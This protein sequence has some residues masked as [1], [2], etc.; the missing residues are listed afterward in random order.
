MNIESNTAWII[1]CK[2]QESG[3]LVNGNLGVP[4]DPANRH[5]QMILDWINAGYIEVDAEL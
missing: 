4:N 3:W 1:S 2:T 5:Y